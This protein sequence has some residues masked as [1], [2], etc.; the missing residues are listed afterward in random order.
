MESIKDS[1]YTIGIDLGGTNVRVALVDSNGTIVNELSKRTE[2]D[3]GGTYLI[4]RLFSMIDRVKGN[5][6]IE[7]VGIGSPG[8][9]DPS[10][11]M[12]VD[13]PNLPGIH[14]FPI[15]QEL[16]KGLS[17]PVFLENDANVAALA[18]ALVG[19]GKGKS[20]VVYI[21]VST[22]IGAG[23]VIDGKVYS[24]A[25]GNA[26]EVG[27]MI[28]LPRG[29]QYSNLNSGALEV[30]SSGTAIGSNAR[31]ILAIRGGAKE[32]FEL[33]ISG[34]KTALSIIETAAEYLAIGIANLLHILDPAIFVLGGGVMQQKELILPMLREKTSKYLY[35]SMQPHLLI[36]PAKL[37]TKAGVIGSGL[38]PWER[39]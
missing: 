10:E 38:L 19:V 28:V 16:E 17:I 8:P 24:G 12:I 2:S 34:D 30:M 4:E 22:G 6:Q 21:T 26:G 13:P 33:A 36:E 37:G 39:F 20:S 27:N 23:I 31:D 1:R 3:K 18:E 5:Y 11:G 9:L 29:P 35:P 7:G 32:V 15:V 14:N 25:N